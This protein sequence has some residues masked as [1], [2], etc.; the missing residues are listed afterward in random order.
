[1]PGNVGSEERSDELDR[2]LRRG[3]AK[4]RDPGAFGKDGFAQPL[5]D[6]GHGHGAPAHIGETD[7]QDSKRIVDTIFHDVTSLGFISGPAGVVKAAVSC[8]NKR[9]RMIGICCFFFLLMARAGA[10]VQSQALETVPAVDLQKYLGKWYEIASF[11]QRF[12]K[13]CHCTTAE[14]ELT[15]KGYV[16]VIN[17]CRKE[18]PTG[19]LTVAKGKAFVVK[20]SNNAKL[21]VQFFWPFRGDYWIIDLA[22]DYSFAVVGAPNRNYLWILSRTTKMDEGLYQEIVNRIAQ[23]GF[24][25]SKLQRMDQSCPD[26]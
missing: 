11:P 18:S 25:V 3:I 9:M 23:K 14:Y 24:D 19:K 2:F 5:F 15:D 12:Q 21:K 8:D 20:G 16:R 4:G 22:Q 26:R 17:S 6:D 7:K 13:G 10:S 1:V